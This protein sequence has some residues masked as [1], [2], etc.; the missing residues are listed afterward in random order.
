MWR[1]YYERRPVRL[2]LQLSQLLRT[3]YGLRFLK[4]HS[5]SYEATRAAFVFKKGHGR[6]DY[7]KA[8]PYLVK[9]YRAIR[10]SGD[11]G[12]DV[13]RVAKL[14]LEWWII[15]RERKKHLSVD[16]DSALAAVQSEIYQMP[17]QAFL[18]HAHLR[19]EA[20]LLRDELAE[21]G[22]VS[23]HNWQNI[24]KL[25]DTSWKSLWQALHNK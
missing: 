16:L 13:D 18:Q 7:E 14:E 2:F 9:Y 6:K 25:L 10:N 3:Q 12:F 19:A 8:L 5:V 1:S 23:D 11:I 15:H 21:T 17:V 24:N 4:S 20:M 22:G